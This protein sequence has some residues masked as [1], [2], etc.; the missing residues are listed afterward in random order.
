MTKLRITT[1]GALLSAVLFLGALPAWS[2]DSRGTILGRLTDSSGSVVPGGIITVTNRA[3]GVTLKGASN[4][5]GNYYFP[6]LIPGMYRISAEKTG[7]KR[8]VRD[9]IE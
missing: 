7:F 8:A 9:E 1:L 4:E 2:Q 5:E 3:T 6:F